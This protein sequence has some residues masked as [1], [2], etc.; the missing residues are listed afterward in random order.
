MIGMKKR[1]SQAALVR[2]PARRR[3]GNKGAADR[4]TCPAAGFTLLEILIAL[5]IV[6]LLMSALYGSYRAVAD[7]ILGVRPLIASDQK[8][9]FFI[10]QLSRQ[11]RCC[12]GGPLSQASQPSA[13]EN[14]GAADLDGRRPLF[15]GKETSQGE[16]L[17]RCVTSNGTRTQNLYPGCLTVIS[18]RLDRWR[19]VLSVQEQ[20]YG[21]RSEEDPEEERIVLEDVIEIELEYFDGKDW[22]SEWDSDTSRGLPRAVRVRLAMESQEGRRIELASVVPILCSDRR[23]D[24]GPIQETP[25]GS[26]KRDAQ[27]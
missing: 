19:H 17:L 13:G 21:R 7:S 5:G 25:A 8:G 16:F 27:E 24:R 4:R 20:L 12:Y 18:Y 2:D 1:P 14:R 6:G 9:R 10:Q 23:V 26:N 15:Q 22:R 3:R 11:I